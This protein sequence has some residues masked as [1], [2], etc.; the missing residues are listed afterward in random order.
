LALSINRLGS[1]SLSRG[2]V[3]GYVS[4]LHPH[5]S[6][7]R[8]DDEA[9]P[10]RV[11]GMMRMNDGTQPAQSKI[12][13]PQ[14]PML[15]SELLLVTLYL[16]PIGPALCLV[17]QRPRQKKLE[18]PHVQDSNHLSFTGGCLLV[19]SG[20]G[21]AHPILRECLSWTR[22]L[23]KHL[24]RHKRLDLCLLAHTIPLTA[25]IAIAQEISSNS[26]QYQVISKTLVRIHP[27]PLTSAF[28]DRSYSE[29]KTCHTGSSGQS[30]RETITVMAN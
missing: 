8:N 27:K 19:V 11:Q 30:F 15:A 29:P 28:F 13:W 23:C 9:T 14:C 21:R 16:L 3:L 24:S 1:Q 25:S 12:F 4:Q 10:Y 18:S 5:P 7:R 17:Q 6:P 26:K 22:L 2:P 20:Q